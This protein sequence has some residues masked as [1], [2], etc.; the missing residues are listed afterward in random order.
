M[1]R[2]NCQF[3]RH[4]YHLPLFEIKHLLQSSTNIKLAGHFWHN[5]D[6][7][8]WHLK[9][10]LR[11]FG[12]PYTPLLLPVQKSFG[13]PETFNLFHYGQSNYKNNSILNVINKK[14]HEIHKV[15]N[16]RSKKYFWNLSIIWIELT[17]IR[18]WFGCWYCCHN[19]SCCLWALHSCCWFC[20]WS[21][22]TRTTAAV[23]FVI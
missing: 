22:S 20:G 19:S 5:V 2:N 1:T 13:G 14:K 10:W 17:I 9:Y 23:V 15:Q 6:R 4:I 18:R 8:S 16:K 21:T 3:F 7:S 12:L 11:S